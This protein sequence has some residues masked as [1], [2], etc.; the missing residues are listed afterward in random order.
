VGRLP[1]TSRSAVPGAFRYGPDRHG[2][3][4]STDRHSHS[5]AHPDPHAHGHADL[6]GN[7]HRHAHGDCHANVYLHAYSN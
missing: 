4:R 7:A 3:S 1:H 2:Y 5:F 6:D